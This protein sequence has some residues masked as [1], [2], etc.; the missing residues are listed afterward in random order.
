MSATIIDLT[1]AYYRDFGFNGD[2]AT[3]PMA[4]GLR[5]TG[6]LHAYAD[7]ARTGETAPNWRP[8]RVASRSAISSS[9]KIKCTPSTT[10]IL[11]F[12]VAR[13]RPRRP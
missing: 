5:F 11:D 7:G 12:P 1:R 9:T 8:S 13:S 10:L 2:F 6:P 4:E 3:V